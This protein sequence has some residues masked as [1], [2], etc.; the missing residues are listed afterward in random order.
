MLY[1]RYWRPGL[2]MVFN[3][4]DTYICSLDHK[5]SVRELGRIARSLR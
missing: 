2:W 3:K 4:F 5:P 1:A